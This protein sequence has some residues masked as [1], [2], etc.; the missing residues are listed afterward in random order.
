MRVQGMITTAGGTCPNEDRVGFH[1]TLAWVIDGATDL[2]DDAAL[3]AE[4]DVHWLVDFVV[5]RLTEAGAR[6]YR[7]SA[8]VLLEDVAEQACRQ[9][10]AYGFPTDRLPP[11]C[12]IAILIDQGDRYEIARIGDA[13]AVVARGDGVTVLTTDFFDRREAAAVRDQ[14]NG[15]TAAQVRAA[16]VRRRLYT[17]TAGDVESV[18]SGHPQRQVRPHTSAVP[19]PTRTMC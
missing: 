19:G 16:I 11:A 12:S 3:P 2:Y 15:G 6:G 7:G 5:E 13:T 4:R 10:E 9:Q 17:M 8:A 1:G 18:F 14:R